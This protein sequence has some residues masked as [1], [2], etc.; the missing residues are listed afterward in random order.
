[1]PDSPRIPLRRPTRPTQ[2]HSGQSLDPVVTRKGGGS[3]M[4]AMILVLAGLVSFC[5]VFDLG[6]LKVFLDSRFSG[7]D[8][9]LRSH[10]NEVVAYVLKALP[11]VGFAIGGVVVLV[12]LTMLGRS[13]ESLSKPRKRK[14]APAEKPKESAVS[15]VPRPSQEFIKPVRL[16]TREQDIKPKATPPMDEPPSKE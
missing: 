11:Y 2:P 14:P 5:Y 8:A 16:A 13:A 4:G 10:N 1:M 12:G 9:N 15:E 6:G 7:V 3:G